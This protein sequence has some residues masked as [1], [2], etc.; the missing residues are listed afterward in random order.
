MEWMHSI[1]GR[2]IIRKN[3]VYSGRCVIEYRLLDISIFYD[4]HF[5]L[6]F[7]Q[8]DKTAQ[9]PLYTHMNALIYK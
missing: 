3:E 1:I 8:T 9:Q 6:F 4:S 7:L 5:L 2:P